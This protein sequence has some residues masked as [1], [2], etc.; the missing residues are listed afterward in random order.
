MGYADELE[1]V[2]VD[3][4]LLDVTSSTG[5]FAA[6]HPDAIDPAKGLADDIRVQVKKATGCEREC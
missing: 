3:E 4:A 5:Q 6:A 1:A 2:S